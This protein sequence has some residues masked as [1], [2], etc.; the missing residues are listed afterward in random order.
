LELVT[1]SL[2]PKPGISQVLLGIGSDDGREPQKVAVDLL[3]ALAYLFRH[4]S[5]KSKMAK[6]LAVEG[7]EESEQIR[8][9]FSQ[10]LTQILTIGDTMQE[11][12]AVSQASGEVLSA[13]FG[14]LSLIDF[15]DTIEIL[16]QR[17]GDELRRKVLRLLEGRLRQNPERDSPSQNRMLDFLP[18]LVTIVESSPDILLKHAAVACIDRITEKY[19]KKDPSKVIPASKAIA[20]Q[21]CIGQEDDRIRIMGVL[22]LASMAE[23][24]GQ[25]MIPA[26]PDALNRSLSLLEVSMEA[27][28]ENARL[29]DAVYSLFSALFVHLPYMI[30]AS[31]LD[32]ILLLSFRSAGSEELEDESRQ[33]ALRLMARKAD[34]AATFGVVNRNWTQ[35]VAAGPEATKE[36]LETLSLAIEKHPKSATM[37]N[38]PVLTEILFKAFD[39]RREQV[40]LG[41]KAKFDADDLE[42]AEEIVNDVTI[43]MIYKLND[44]TF[45][46]IFTKLFDWATTGISKKDR[47]GDVSRLTTFYKFLEVFFG[48]LQVCIL[49]FQIDGLTNA[50]SPS[51]PDTQATLSRMSLRSLARPVLPTRTPGLSGYRLCACSGMLLSMIRMVS[52][53]YY[54]P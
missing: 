31:H 2:R 12:K 52:L 28:K 43:K 9:Y 38:L 53:I 29:H 4:S 36:T 32:Q 10:I 37:K 14:T 27:G 1:D 18:T 34:L 23:V 16:L 50:R 45:R 7:G 15:L 47:H 30:S 54:N 13:L 46:P 33:E 40:A 11:M 41:S 8:S 48:T 44:S 24:L 20:G 25:A 26:L 21:S 17:P 51:S 5:I 35:A 3:R 6:A 22:C 49:R 42:E 39:L 19:G